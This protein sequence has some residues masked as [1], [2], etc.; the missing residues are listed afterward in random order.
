MFLGQTGR[1]THLH[2]VRRWLLALTLPGLLAAGG[3]SRFKQHI[4][5]SIDNNPQ[6]RQN[7]V[8]GARKSCVQSAM[9]KAPKIPGIES[10]IDNYCDCF[11]TKGLGQFSNSELAS[12]GFHGGHFTPE[13]QRKLNQAVQMCSNALFQHKDRKATP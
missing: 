10:K 8:D 5:E 4:R 3:C 6:V 1:S 7:A 13:Q 12:I 11:A 2:P 9:A